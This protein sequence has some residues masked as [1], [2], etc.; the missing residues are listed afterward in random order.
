M[1]DDIVKEAFVAPV[2]AQFNPLEESCE[3]I[4]NSEVCNEANAPPA[5]GVNETL[6]TV[7]DILAFVGGFIAVVIVVVAGIS[8]IVAGGDSGKIAN[9]RNAIIYALVGAVVIVFARAIVLYIINRV[10]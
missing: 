6:L 10:G 3:G 8:M 5:E 1:M 4:S 9:S 2:V 7:V